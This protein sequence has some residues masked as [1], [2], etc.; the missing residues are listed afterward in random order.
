M[1]ALRTL[2]LFT[3]I[4]D[5]EYILSHLENDRDVT[6]RA[7]GYPLQDASFMRQSRCSFLNV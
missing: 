6:E 5:H 7:Q 1:L 3:I 2:G 4:S